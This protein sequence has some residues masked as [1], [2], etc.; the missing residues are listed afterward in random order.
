MPRPE[1]AAPDAGEPRK[2]A[3]LSDRLKPVLPEGSMYQRRPHQGKAILQHRQSPNNGVPAHFGRNS[4]QS[5]LLKPPSK[6][7]VV[8]FPASTGGLLPAPQEQGKAWA[9]RTV[10]IQGGGIPA[11]SGRKPARVR[12]LPHPRQEATERLRRPVRQ[13]LV[14]Y[15]IWEAPVVFV[16]E[17]LAR[18]GRNCP[19]ARFPGA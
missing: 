13:E 2:E 17:V 10:R 15:L 9:V 4:A 11:R 6:K 16:I 5:L 19:E 18:H 3:V 8:L 7:A 14:V 1:E 12:S